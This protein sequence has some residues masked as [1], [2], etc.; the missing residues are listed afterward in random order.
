[1]DLGRRASFLLPLS[2]IGCTRANDPDA[3][4]AAFVDR[5]FVERD[6]AKALEL[7]ADLAARRVKDEQKLLQESGVGA[8]GP[9]PRVF[10]KLLRR[11]A[12]AEDT[13]LV[14]ALTIDADGMKLR[15]E[16]RLVVKPV[17][18]D[19]KVVNFSENDVAP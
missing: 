1:M 15:K 14:Y 6:H 12:R 17:G 16:L 13:E 9:Q 4:G 11:S 10:Y 5:Y 3:V 18:Q 8:A 7:S 2:L 19:L